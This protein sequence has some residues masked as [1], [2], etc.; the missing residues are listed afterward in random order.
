MF[1]FSIA[2]AWSL[3]ICKNELLGYKMIQKCYE[4]T[5]TPF[6][7]NMREFFCWNRQGVWL[8]NAKNG[9]KCELEL[10]LYDT[11]KL[12]TCVGADRFTWYRYDKDM[13]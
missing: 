13:L 5:G 11:A 6:S 3:I 4:Y 8:N 2:I 1:A 7:C 10:R 12:I 9:Y